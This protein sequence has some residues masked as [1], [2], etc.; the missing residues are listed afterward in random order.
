MTSFEYRLH[1]VDMV[2]A[3]ILIYPSEHAET[4]AKFYR[5]HTATAPEEFGAFLA[6][7]QGPPVPFLPEQWHGKPVLV[8]VGMW[9]GDPARG[10]AVAAVPGRR[11]GGGIR[12]GPYA[13]PRPESAFDPM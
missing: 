2:H 4:V 9:T 12:G 11:T 5:D 13:V 3:G 1:P 7:H 8:I 10:P 6:F